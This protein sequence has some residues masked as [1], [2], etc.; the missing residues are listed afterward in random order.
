[1]SKSYNNYIV[2]I[3]TYAYCYFPPLLNGGTSIFPS[4][5]A[6]ILPQA[7]LLPTQYCL[8]FRTYLLQVF[9]LS[10]KFYV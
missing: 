8:F 5:K 4:K 9:Y 7:F 6:C 2:I 1:M 10:L 3:T